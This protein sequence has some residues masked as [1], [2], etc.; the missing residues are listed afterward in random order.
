MN[1]IELE[2]RL[3][4]SRVWTLN[5]FSTLPV[6]DLTRPATASEHDPA[7]FWSAKDHLAHLSGIEKTFNA[8]IRRHLGGD[9]NP[10]ALRTGPDGESRSREQVMAVVHAM[11]EA[12]VRQHRQKPLSAVVALGQSVRAETLTLL[13]EL[14]DEQ[15]G[16]ALP[17]APWADGTI[18]G[19]LGTNAA[20]VRMHWDWLTAG[21]AGATQGVAA[22]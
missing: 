15:L 2:I 12:W 6:E 7:T 21:L 3:H 1:R 13:S 14:T 11:T 22:P 16:E 18:G 10:V 8:M 4:E 20:H 9:T 17:G 5:Q 19:V